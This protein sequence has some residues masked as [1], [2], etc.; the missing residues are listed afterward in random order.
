MFVHLS[1]AALADD[2]EDLVAVGDVI[3]R[4]LDVGALVVVV[5]AVVGSANHP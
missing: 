5:A 4:H 1:E 2:L 3:V